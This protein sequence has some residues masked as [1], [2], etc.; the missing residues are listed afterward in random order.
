MYWQ[1]WWLIAL[2][3]VIVPMSVKMLI[4][5]RQGWS[6]PHQAWS[7]DHPDDRYT[8]SWYVK[9][10]LQA[11][12]GLSVAAVFTAGWLYHAYNKAHAEPRLPHTDSS[13]QVSPQRGSAGTVPITPDA[14]APHGSGLRVVWRSYAGRLGCKFD[15]I[16]AKETP[17]RVTVTVY[18][19]QSS[20]SHGLCN[21]EGTSSFGSFGPRTTRYADVALQTVLG[22]RKVMN[23]HGT[24]IPTLKETQ[25]S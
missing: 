4:N 19:G 25:H 21:G 7:D 15:H 17:S 20:T 13:E 22:D 14:Y 12:V 16:Q 18:E 6:R 3:V 10:E 24:E 1:P 23:A 5:P 9:T 2:W 11:L 8:Q